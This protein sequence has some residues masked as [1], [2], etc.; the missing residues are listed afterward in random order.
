[1]R[2][3]PEQIKE[4]IEKVFDDYSK[5]P[6]V[7]YSPFQIAIEAKEITDDHILVSVDQ[8]YETPPLNSVTVQ[9]LCEAFGT[10]HIDETEQ[11]SEGGCE[12]C[13]YGSSYGWTIRI[14]LPNWR[15]AA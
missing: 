8:M 14:K 7:Y 1:M 13:D 15:D 9:M 3:T 10:R 4:K 5:H 12:T 2:Y 6:G 11:W